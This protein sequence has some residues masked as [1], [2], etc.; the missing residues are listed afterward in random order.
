[1]EKCI[2]P[3]SNTYTSAYCCMPVSSWIYIC[4]A[5]PIRQLDMRVWFIEASTMIWGDYKR[6]LLST[7]LLIKIKYKNIK[8]III[9][10]MRKVFAGMLHFFITLSFSL[11]YVRFRCE[12]KMCFG[13]LECSPMEICS[14]NGC[15]TN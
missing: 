2:C 8:R 4:I 15:E 6:K 12:S 1:M 3:L 14:K 5:N 11:F 10:I 9:K 13:I 7:I